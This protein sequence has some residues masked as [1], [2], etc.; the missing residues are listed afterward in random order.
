MKLL[1]PRLLGSHTACGLA[2]VLFEVWKAATE[3][4]FAW[5]VGTFEAKM[6]LKNSHFFDAA[7]KKFTEL[8]DTYEC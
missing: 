3:E 8:C 1:K 2:G 5:F 7:L 6:Q 4:Q